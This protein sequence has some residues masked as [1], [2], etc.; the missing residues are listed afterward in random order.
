M[1]KIN[2]IDLKATYGLVILTGT[3]KLLE[4]PER[5]EP[6]QTDFLDQ[7]G[8]DYYLNTMYLKDKEVTLSCAFL[9]DNDTQF[10]LN[11]NAFFTEITGV[12]LKQLYI[13]DHTQ[14]YSIFYKRTGNFKKTLKR[15]K[16]VPKVFV[17][18]DLII[19]VVL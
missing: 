17:K 2:N 7:N 9:A 8:T 14:A 5:K 16:N 13:D 10:W 3:E 6:L 12:G 15:L 1:D 11:Y 19:Q 4:Y 18:F